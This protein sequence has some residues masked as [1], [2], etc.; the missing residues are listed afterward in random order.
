MWEKY[1][2]SENLRS[3]ALQK[4]CYQNVNFSCMSEKNSV[5]TIPFC[6]AYLFGGGLHASSS[7]GTKTMARYM[8]TIRIYND[9]KDK[10]TFIRQTAYRRCTEFTTTNSLDVVYRFPQV[11]SWIAHNIFHQHERCRS[12]YWGH[13]IRPSNSRWANTAVSSE[14][15]QNIY[16]CSP[17]YSHQ[18]CCLISSFS[19]A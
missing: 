4:T 1:H 17:C 14:T 9:P 19:N 16:H 13:Y 6:F 7:P 8:T 15:L 2:L 12:R 5:C 11:S 10:R 3:H 18:P